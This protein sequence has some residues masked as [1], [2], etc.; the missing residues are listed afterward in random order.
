[1][2]HEEGGIGE[3]DS[4]ERS[5]KPSDQVEDDNPSQGDVPSVQAA[6]RSDSTKKY[7]K[8]SF[9]VSANSVTM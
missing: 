2:D 5:R 9:V 3:R 7:Q 6:R 8:I 4:P 1:M